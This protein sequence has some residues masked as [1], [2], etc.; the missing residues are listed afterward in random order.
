MRTEV[1]RL[2]SARR[3]RIVRRLARSET[4]ARALGCGEADVGTVV[5]DRGKVFILP[6]G[7][8][9]VFLG[10]LFVM[11][12]GSV[13]YN[14]NLGLAFTFMVGGALLVSILYS[15]RN[16]AGLG[17]RAGRVE[18]VF[19][20]QRAVFSVC[21]Q[22]MADRSRQSLS[23]VTADGT[24]VGFD[25][26]AG[27]HL[28][29]ALERPTVER[30]RLR[31]GR[32]R[33][34]TVFPL[35]IFCAWSYLEPTVACTVYPKPGPRLP[36]PEAGGLTGTGKRLAAA[37]SE[38]FAGLRAY[39]PG[40][41]PRQVHWKS[42]A[43]EMDPQ[44]KLFSGVSGA[45]LWLEWEDLAAVGVEARLAQMCRW[46]LD[47]ESS[48]SRYG[49][50]IPGLRIPSARGNRHRGRCLEALALFRLP[51]PTSTAARPPR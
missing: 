45:E 8:G 4:L 48:G 25:V 50:T 29:P 51:A 39:R 37:G 31:L 43:R 40:D 24:R 30:G 10:V 42:V 1:G 46:V 47:A 27:G 11:L 6:T 44:T 3:D 38:D 35:G 32:V 36:L 22:D 13:N 14:N 33:V 18:P 2:R 7:Y 21:V 9:L 23:L 34:E 12:V 20:G 49:L 41:S 16:L 17:L 19:A 5:L 15:Y 26:P 28:C